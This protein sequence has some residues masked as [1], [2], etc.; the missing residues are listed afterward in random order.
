MGLLP[1]PLRVQVDFDWSQRAA[2]LDT[3]V[4][5]LERRVDGATV[6][7]SRCVL[8]LE[9]RDEKDEVICRS[10]GDPAPVHKESSAC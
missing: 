10:R 5:R 6:D 2:A 4:E 3:A 1:V 8:T 9:L 7:R